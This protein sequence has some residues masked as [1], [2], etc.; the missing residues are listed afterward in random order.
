[1]VM[2][3][4][5]ER[6]CIGDFGLSLV[7]DTYALKL[8]SS[9][10]ISLK[11]TT[12]YLSPELLMGGSTPSK[13]SDIYAFACVCYEIF[14]GKIPFH[15]LKLEASVILAVAID[16]KHPSRPESTSLNDTMWNIMVNCW[17]ADFHLRPSAS[18]VFTDVARLESLKTGDS[19]KPA[20]DWDIQNLS[21]IWKNVKHP[22]IDV[23]EL[24]R[25]QN[26]LQCS[27]AAAAAAQSNVSP[28]QD[29]PGSA[30]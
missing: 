21:Q 6:A 26:S 2:I 17:D 9:K 7:A 28:S 22:R 24:A 19:I 30:C 10:E 3:T 13:F 20:P 29:L 11:G 25:L 5:D 14:E 12:R 27:A 1:N 18:E 4:P 8:T 23:S 15:A 16:K